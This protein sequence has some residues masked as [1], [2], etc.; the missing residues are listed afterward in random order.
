LREP[1]APSLDETQPPG[2]GRS[3]GE[4]GE[5]EQLIAAIEARDV[6]L[7]TVVM[8]KHLRRGAAR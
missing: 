8:G 2:T 6:E 1:L 5:H 4:G 7:A 3:R